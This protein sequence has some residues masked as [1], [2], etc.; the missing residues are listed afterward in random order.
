MD[1]DP[2]LAVT[3]VGDQCR[4]SRVRRHCHV[5]CDSLDS[6][7]DCLAKGTSH[8]NEIQATPPLSRDRADTGLPSCAPW[9][10]RN[11]TCP[12]VTLLGT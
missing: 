6:R 12:V 10:C 11:P 7:G 4:P 1:R 3:G 8:I 9:D 5:S 2:L